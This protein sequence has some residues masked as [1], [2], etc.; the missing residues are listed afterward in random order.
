MLQKVLLKEL[1]KLDYLR[2]SIVIHSGDLDTLKRHSDEAKE[3]SEGNECGISIKDFNDIQ[4]NDIIECY[5]IES[6]PR[7][8]RRKII[9]SYE[10]YLVTELEELEKIS[11]QFYQNFI[12]SKTLLMD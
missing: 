8:L 2:D 5:E 3:V 10:N 4:V 9:F 7:K 1:V 11:E 6:T 12:S